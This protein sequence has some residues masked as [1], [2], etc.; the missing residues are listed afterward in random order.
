[1]DAR[2]KFIKRIPVEIQDVRFK[3]EERLSD[4]AKKAPGANYLT[5]GTDVMRDYLGAPYPTSEGRPYGKSENQPAA[6]GQPGIN[7]DIRP[8]DVG[9]VPGGA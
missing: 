7:S 6:I 3:P 5:D 1:M 2:G 8:A 4:P 9:L